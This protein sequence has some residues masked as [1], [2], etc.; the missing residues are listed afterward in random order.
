LNAN[1]LILDYLYSTFI[2]TFKGI[3]AML[4]K[5]HAQDDIILV[6]EAIA[7]LIEALSLRKAEER[8]GGNMGTVAT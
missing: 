8:F 5:R 6:K 1:D 7:E 3:Q 2:S 4:E